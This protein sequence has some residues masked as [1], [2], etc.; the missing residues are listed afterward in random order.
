M[1]AADAAS[2]ALGMVLDH[3]GPGESRISMVVRADMVN[4][5]DICHGGLIATLADSA[6]AVACNGHGA[7]TVAAGFQVDFLE[8]AR[9]GDHLVAEARE[10]ALRG[11]SGVYDVTVRRGDTVIAE[12][13]G[14]S[15][16]RKA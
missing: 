12:F 9:L 6:F 7:V 10:V 14:R 8:P 16:S 3:A 4:G 2:K 11:R 1:W 15:R 13:R 5:W